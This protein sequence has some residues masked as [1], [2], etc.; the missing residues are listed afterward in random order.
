MIKP[1]CK[2]ESGTEC[3]SRTIGCH[4]QCERFMEYKRLRQECKERM[5][6]DKAAQ[7]YVVDNTIRQ[8]HSYRHPTKSQR[9]IM[10][11]R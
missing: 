3:Q 6:E 9:K 8:R 2:D 4:E 5:Q 7:R 10:G 1:P 11:Q